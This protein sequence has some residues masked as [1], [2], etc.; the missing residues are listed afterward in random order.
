MIFLEDTT[1]IAERVQQSKL[2]ALG[3]LSASIAHEIR[4]PIG[5]MSHAGQLLAESPAYRRGGPAPHRHHPRATRE[6][7]SQII[8]NVLALSRREQTR[9]ERLQLPAWLEDFAREFCANARSSTTAQLRWSMRRGDARLEVSVDPTHLHQIAVEPVRERAASTR[10]AA[11]GAIA[12]EIRCGMLAS[13]GRP[14]VEVADR[15]PAS[16]RTDVGARSSSRSSPAATAARASDCSSPASWRRRN[17]ADAAATS[18]APGGGSLF[19]L[20][21]ADPGRWEASE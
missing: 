5:A 10:S 11:A 21:F 6:R 9:P 14:F 1:L 3:R 12:V 17:G 18:R 13:N 4:N 19:R 15:G 20:V 8:E 16:R 2:A 7:V